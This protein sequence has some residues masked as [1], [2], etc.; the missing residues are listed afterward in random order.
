VTVRTRFA[1]S[2]TGRLHL[3]NVRAAAFNWLLAR[4][5][6]GG[7]ILRVED[8]DTERNVEGGEEAIV[9]DLRWLG[10]DWDEGPDV[11][12]P[13]GPYRQSE[14]DEAYGAA[15][16]RLVDGGAGYPCFC[17]EEDLAEEAEEYGE[18]RTALR[19]SGRCRGLSA[20][21]RAGRVARG[22]AHVIRFAVPEGL[23]GVKVK[24]EIFGR[25]SVPTADI[26]DFV[27]RR[28]DGRVTYNF[29]VVVDDVGMRITHVVRGVGHL[30]NTPKQALLFDALG[31]ERPVFAHLPTVLGPDGRKLSKRHGAAAVADLREEG[32]PPDAVLNYLSLLGWSHPEEREV[33]TRE[34]LTGSMVLDRV[35]KS[36]TQL[37][38]GK[39]RWVAAQH[40][41]TETLE[42]LAGH[43]RPFL[44][45]DRYPEATENL[46]GVVDTLRT[47]MSTYGDLNEHLYLIFP[48]EAEVGPRRTEIG[49][50]S[51]AR[52][53]LASVREAL[54]AYPDWNA[55]DLDK[56]IRAAGAAVEAKGAALFHPVRLVLIG[57]EKGPDLGKIM[58]A[59][60]RDEAFRRI[61]Q[62]LG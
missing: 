46:E 25:I 22:E 23:G 37:D 61:D 62:A 60:G 56:T 45:T 19:Y 59:L 3:G 42:E 24:D 32:Y 50:N 6:G 18:G 35:G 41:A 5:H 9:E 55:E 21:E 44:A 49:R 40:L 54:G 34:E 2:P 38:L 51:E 20:E 39:L 52:K 15:L 36:D 29:A 26:G 10:L 27:I 1:P 17:S 48:S 31:A 14:R 16:A 53:V 13:H 7:F 12:G 57:S 30:S 11:G 58:V 4:R 33:L 43:V 47:R 28:T 8:T